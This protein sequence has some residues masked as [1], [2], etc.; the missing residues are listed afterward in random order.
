MKIANTQADF[1]MVSQRPTRIRRSA[2]RIE[3]PARRAIATLPR[4]STQA[5]THH[6]K[7]VALV[8]LQHA[9]DPAILLYP[10]LA[11]WLQILGLL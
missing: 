3:H 6:Q 2:V 5:L 11:A 8:R 1:L 10:L 9:R 4:G 7:V